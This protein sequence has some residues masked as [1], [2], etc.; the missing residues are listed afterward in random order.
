[1]LGERARRARGVEKSVP[2]VRMKVYTGIPPS[3]YANSPMGGEPRPRVNNGNSPA[4]WMGGIKIELTI[5]SHNIENCFLQK[6][7]VFCTLRTE[8]S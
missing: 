2:T 5:F 6:F 3:C 8:R 1:M 4:L 7:C